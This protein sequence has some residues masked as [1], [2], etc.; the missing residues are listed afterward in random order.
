[1]FYKSATSALRPVTIAPRVL[2]RGEFVREIKRFFFQRT[3]RG[4]LKKISPSVKIKEGCWGEISKTMSSKQCSY[5][6]GGGRS[7]KLRTRFLQVCT[8]GLCDAYCWVHLRKEKGFRVM[9][10]NIPNGGKGLFTERSLPSNYDIGEY[11]GVT[12]RYVTDAGT[13]YD[14]ML[15]GGRVVDASDPLQSSILRYCN[16]KPFSRSNVRIVDRDMGTSH[17]GYRI[18]RTRKCIRASRDNPVELFVCYG[19]EYWKVPK[20]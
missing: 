20:K 1:M 8:G 9:D 19:R 11:V 7:C 10:S 13:P 14:L 3:A 18:Y 4:A 5:K 2:S 17:K 12:R 6:L 15:R 16:H